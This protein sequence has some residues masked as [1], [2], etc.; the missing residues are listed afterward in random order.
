VLGYHEAEGFTRSGLG[1]DDPWDATSVL[2]A[3]GALPETLAAFAAFARPGLSRY[4]REYAAAW[5]DWFRGDHAYSSPTTYAGNS[6][7]VVFPHVMAR[8]MLGEPVAACL[9]AAE[10]AAANR[11]NA[12]VGPPVL[13]ELLG[14]AAPLR[15]TEWQPAALRDAH[16]S[17]DGRRVAMEFTLHAP[18]DWT[19]EMEARPRVRLVRAWVAGKQAPITQLG[20]RCTVRVRA[21]GDVRVI[22]E[23]GEPAPP[24]ARGASRAR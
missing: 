16:T 10:G 11:N 7:Y 23:L 5:P 22:V 21:T 6:V 13:A 17:A 9:R 24:A 20:S 3:D 4:L 19:L 14:R 15:I 12:W 1:T 8:S 2:S 18:T